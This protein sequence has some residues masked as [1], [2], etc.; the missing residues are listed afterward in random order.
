[1]TRA[2][3]RQRIRNI[4]I[5]ALLVLL[6]IA[7]YHFTRGFSIHK[8]QDKYY[9][10]FPNVAG[11]D[12]GTPVEVK[13][14][15]IGH[16]ASMEL[17]Y[18]DGIKVLFDIDKDVRFPKGTV[19]WLEPGGINGGQG[20]QVVMGKGPG[21]L[22]IGT[23]LETKRDTGFIDNLNY[24]SGVYI[25][26]GRQILTLLDTS[27]RKFNYILHAGL[28]HDILNGVFYLDKQTGKF[29]AISGEL[30][31]YDITIENGLVKIDSSTAN[32][33]AKNDNLNKSIYKMDTTMADLA[34][35]HYKE[36]LDTLKDNIKSIGAS[37][38]KLKDNKLLNDK[39]AYTKANASLDSTR[40]GIKEIKE[41]PSAHWM[42]VFGKNKKK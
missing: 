23:M 36:S 41:H 35:K 29:R 42:A 21:I 26:S 37:I 6:V 25:R 14:V 24:K 2:R 7:V 4:G 34:N 32:L 39:T 33:A 17:K 27:I 40:S 13:G 31:G 1:M 3:K 18:G 8:A 16:V 38:G 15:Q 19:I 20:I 5:A 12:I 28:L 11:L 10:N 9:G 22:P 30:K